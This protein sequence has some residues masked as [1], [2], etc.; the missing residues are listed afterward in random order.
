MP[1]D[2]VKTFWNSVC[3]KIQCWVTR[4][5][6]ESGSHLELKTM[7]NGFRV[8]RE[9]PF[10]EVERWLADNQI[11]GSAKYSVG[12]TP[13]MFPPLTVTGENEARLPPDPLI[14][15]VALTSDDV[16]GWVISRFE[17]SV[18]R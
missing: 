3:V 1:D 6:K 13:S 9:S 2:P 15:P 16:A 12:D 17:Q 18:R 4:E 5:N 7:P 11:H 10:L 8:C 14:K